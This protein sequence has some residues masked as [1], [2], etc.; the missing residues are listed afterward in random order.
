MLPTKV[1]GAQARQSGEPRRLVPS[2]R[3][4]PRQ[5]GLSRP[6]LIADDPSQLGGRL[7]Q[8]AEAERCELEERER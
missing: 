3:R 7:T 6:A 5:A 4:G 1:Q 2:Q 8:V